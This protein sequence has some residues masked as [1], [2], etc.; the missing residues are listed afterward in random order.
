MTQIVLFDLM[1][2]LNSNCCYL[3]V[4]RHLYMRKELKYFDWHTYGLSINDYIATL[5]FLIEMVVLQ[6]NVFF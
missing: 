3:Q 2:N 1:I 4:I 6:N 5:D